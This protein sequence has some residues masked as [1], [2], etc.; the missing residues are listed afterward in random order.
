MYARDPKFSP[1]D[2]AYCEELESAP[3]SESRSRNEE[4]KGRGFPGSEGYKTPF[5]YDIPK[6]TSCADS[7]CP[8]RSIHK[9]LLKAE[10]RVSPCFL[11]E[12]FGI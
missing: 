9:Y 1:I 7:P 2:P 11:R 4:L 10:S 8:S 12:V 5:R 3:G 6:L